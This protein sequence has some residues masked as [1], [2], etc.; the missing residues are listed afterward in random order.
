MMIREGSISQSAL[1]PPVGAVRQRIDWQT[2]FENTVCIYSVG[3]C[4][5][6]ISLDT[7]PR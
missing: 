4:F 3:E 1:T 2:D 7:C 5:D 6:V